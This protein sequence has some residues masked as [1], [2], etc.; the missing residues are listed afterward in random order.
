MPEKRCEFGV[1][2]Y[3]KNGYLVLKDV[4]FPKDEE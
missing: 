4:I 3:L 1:A 2:E